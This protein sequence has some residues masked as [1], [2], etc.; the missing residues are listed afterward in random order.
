MKQ[1][2]LLEQMG[3]DRKSLGDDVYGGN[4]VGGVDVQGGVEGNES[5]LGED[6]YGGVHECVDECEQLQELNPCVMVEER[7]KEES[8]EGVPDPFLDNLSVH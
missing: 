3:E 2:L 5:P 7:S 4:G 1:G 6:V 8:G